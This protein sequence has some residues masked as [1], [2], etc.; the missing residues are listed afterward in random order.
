[1]CLQNE[2]NKLEYKY[3]RLNRLTAHNPE[4][5]TEWH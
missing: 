2:N 1:M 5:V 3:A 4:S